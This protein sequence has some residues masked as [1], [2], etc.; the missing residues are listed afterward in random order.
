MNHKAHSFL[1]TLYAADCPLNTFDSMTSGNVALVSP[2][3]TPGYAVD[4]AATLGVLD[5]SD[6]DWTHGQEMGLVTFEKSSAALPLLLYFRHSEDGYRLY[7]RSGAHFGEGVFATTHGLVEVKPIKQQD[8]TAWRI[9]QASS[10]NAFDLTTCEGDQVDIKLE[11]KSGPWGRNALYP[12]G[13]YSVCH[14]NATGSTLK[15]VI[16]E[17]SVDWLNPA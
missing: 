8:P 12:V 9:T 7:V 14:A 11:S 2:L 10:G 1:A 4:G 3:T 15:L 6:D 5:C 13:D 16:Q 17:R